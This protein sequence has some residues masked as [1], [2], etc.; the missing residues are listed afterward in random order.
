MIHI[1]DPTIIWTK[2][3]VSRFVSHIFNLKK[4]EGLSPQLTLFFFTFVRT[5]F[6][7]TVNVANGNVRS[8]GQSRSATDPRLH[9]EQFGA[10]QTTSPADGAFQE[11]PRRLCNRIDTDLWSGSFRDAACVDLERYSRCQTET[12]TNESWNWTETQTKA[13]PELK[14]NWNSNIFKPCFTTF[15]EDYFKNNNNTDTTTYLIILLQK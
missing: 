6:H 3:P 5:A 10:W 2:A 12:Q 11:H 9:R 7:L 8:S 4:V 15:P 14:L 1:K 13:E